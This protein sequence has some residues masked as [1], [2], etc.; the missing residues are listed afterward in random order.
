[1]Y[2]YTNYMY[3]L[4][5]HKLKSKAQLR[6][7][8]SFVALTEKLGIHRNTLNYY[9]G[10]KPIFPEAISKVLAILEVEPQEVISNTV[11]K[12]PEFPELVDLVDQL[13]EKYP[14]ICVTLFGSRAIKQ[15]RTYSDYDIG[16]YAARGIP[17]DKYLNLKSLVSD[18]EEHNAQRI[19]LLNLELADH[20]FLSNIAPQLKFLGGRYKDWLA[21]MNRIYG[22]EK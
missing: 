13:L 8:P 7:Y 6:G 19:D 12:Q 16:L 10:A 15:N 17:T 5:K 3:I 22:H 11:L 21:L 18:F 9:L 20:E 14:P 4:D 1:M 2:K